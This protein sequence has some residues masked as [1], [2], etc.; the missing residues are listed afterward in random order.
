LLGD[1]FEQ[2]ADGGY[3]GC[4]LGGV[5]QDAAYYGIVR[6][7]AQGQQLWTK[8]IG[9]ESPTGYASAMRIIETADGG[10]V[11]AGVSNLE[12]VC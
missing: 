8:K 4:C 1:D 9:C 3:L 6:F 12:P 2:T 11:V 5:G 7:D 10:F